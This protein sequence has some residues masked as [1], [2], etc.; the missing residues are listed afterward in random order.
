MF[1]IGWNMRVALKD[2]YGEAGLK[3]G[4][5]DSFVSEPQYIQAFPVQR[6][7]GLKCYV[8]ASPSRPPV[9]TD[10][11]QMIYI[12]LET[13]SIGQY[14]I[15]RQAPKR[16]CSRCYL[17]DYLNA[18]SFI[19]FGMPD[20]GIEPLAPVG[21][22]I[23]ED[24][25]VVCNKALETLDQCYRGQFNCILANSTW[26]NYFAGPFTDQLEPKKYRKYRFVSPAEIFGKDE[27]IDKE[28]N[29]DSYLIKCNK[30]AIQAAYAN[31]IGH[32][33]MDNDNGSWAQCEMKE[34]IAQH[35]VVNRTRD[36]KI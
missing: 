32:S 12:Q 31:R 27:I 34:S 30:H 1:F 19:L 25:V 3:P 24:D 21:A 2:I 33:A 8:I 7:P 14:T 35:I 15:P 16:R 18:L 11:C 36:I 29:V 20:K 6:Y 4:F 22:V 26:M 28:N 23:I 10:N 13:I 9:I 17:S 5:H